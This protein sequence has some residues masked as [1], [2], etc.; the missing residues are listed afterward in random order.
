M[1]TT[2]IIIIN[3]NSRN[4]SKIVVIRL[5]F[6]YYFGGSRNQGPSRKGIWMFRALALGRKTSFCVAHI[7]IQ[8][9]LC[10]MYV[11]VSQNKE[12]PI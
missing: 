12:T 3:R 11:V 4:S 10:R 5:F 9:F 8:I 2:T 6:V 1:I 7:R